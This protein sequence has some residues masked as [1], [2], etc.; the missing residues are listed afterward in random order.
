M[1]ASFDFPMKTTSTHIE[2]LS[3][4]KPYVN[5]WRKLTIAIDGVDGSGKSTLARFLA[6]QLG[7]PAIET[8]LFLI[9]DSREPT[10]DLAL[11]RCL[12]EFRHRRDRPVIVEGI[13]ILRT[14][15][16]LAIVPD[17]VIRV[18]SAGCDGSYSWMQQFR[19]YEEEYLRP[20]ELDFLFSWAQNEDASQ[21]V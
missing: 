4:L 2:L 15:G 20:N 19:T 11:L 18:E 21:F 17:F 10:L 12:V 6:W 9:A 16:Q 3:K 14:L 1:T 13:F 7:M 8:D 5:P